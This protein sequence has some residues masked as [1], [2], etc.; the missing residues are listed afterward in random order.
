LDSPAQIAIE[1]KALLQLES[2]AYTKVREHFNS[3]ANTA[4]EP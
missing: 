4:I 3:R 2:G 1:G